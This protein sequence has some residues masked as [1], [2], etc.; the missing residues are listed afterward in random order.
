MK[1]YYVYILECSDQKLYVGVTNNLERRVAEHQSGENKSAFTF[2]RRPV[3]LVYHI[4][5]YSIED[6]ILFEKQLKGWT[7]KKKL[8]L[9]NGEFEKLPALSKKSFKKKEG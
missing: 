9:I 5:F 2:L 6:A 3:K 8:A 1:S 7:R 4:E